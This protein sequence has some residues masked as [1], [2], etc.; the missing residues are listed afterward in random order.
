MSQFEHL[1]SPITI[2]G[3]TLKNR[4]V[5]PGMGTKM[6]QNRFPTEQLIDF[7]VARTKGGTGLNIVEVSSVHTP[8]A[9]PTYGC[10]SEDRYIP[11]YQKL[12]KAIHDAG[13]QGRGVFVAGWLGNCGRPVCTNYSAQR[14]ACERRQDSQG[15]QR[16]VD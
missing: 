15:C 10:L 5:M 9:P 7:H 11:A 12:T 2:R 3:L 6:M 14:Y 4:I 16:G 8:S 1:F 13:G